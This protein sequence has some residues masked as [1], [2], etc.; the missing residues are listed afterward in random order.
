ME[1]YVYQTK[2]ESAVVKAFYAVC[3]VIVFAGIGIMMA[4]RG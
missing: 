2:V 4:W 1:K 3:T